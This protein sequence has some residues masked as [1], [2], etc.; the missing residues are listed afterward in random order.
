MNG[1]SHTT[2][3][4]SSSSSTSQSHQ[5]SFLLTTKPSMLVSRPPSRIVTYRIP[6]SESSIS[7]SVPIML[8]PRLDLA[9][10]KETDEPSK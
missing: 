1:L 5:P 9:T 7:F 10:S 8:R 6:T 2:P 3:S 4:S